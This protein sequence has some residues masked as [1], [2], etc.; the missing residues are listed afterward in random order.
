MGY[1]ASANGDYDEYPD[2]D[3]ARPP[4]PGSP[5]GTLRGT[6]TDDNKNPV[7]GAL[8]GLGG[9]DGPPAAGPALQPRTGT[10]GTYTIPGIPQAGYRQ[11]TVEPPAPLANA[12]AG[13]ITVN[14]GVTTKD[15]TVRRNF[16]DARGGGQIT[17]DARDDAPWGC[18]WRNLID[19]DQANVLETASP[20]QDDPKTPTTD[21]TRP[22]TFTVTLSEP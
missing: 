9:H 1:F 7:K 22:R 13:P 6:V 14:G 10:D 21:E 11:L 3:F 18:G 4:A 17:S 15:V 20:V 2:A 16:A 12:L 5:T 19:G 8:V